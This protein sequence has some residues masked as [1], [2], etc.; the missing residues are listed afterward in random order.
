MKKLYQLNDLYVDPA[1]RGKGVSKLLIARAKQLVL[2][3][4]A[5]G[6]MLETKKS[7]VIGNSLYSSSGMKMTSSDHNYYDWQV[8]DQVKPSV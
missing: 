2:E 7:N 5:A 6:F 3:T 8:C 1:H 4:S